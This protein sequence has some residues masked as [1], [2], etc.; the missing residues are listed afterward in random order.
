MLTR[1]MSACRGG[2]TFCQTETPPPV[3]FSP[4]FLLCS[5]NS[6]NPLTILTRYPLLLG[7]AC[8]VPIGLLQA[9]SP[10][11]TIAAHRVASGPRVD[12]I[13]G[14]EQWRGVSPDTSFEQFDP[15]EGAAPTE[16]TSVRLVYDD[17]ALY[18]AS[19][20]NAPLR[21]GFAEQWTGGDRPG[22]PDG[23]SGF[24]DSS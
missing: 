5:T 18:G 2:E 3:C 9:E 15:E 1:S 7:L 14:D 16:R 11:K 4:S 17:L 19:F 12:G 6:I 13:L 23:F 22:R 20:A 8:L 21:D 24:I 10:T